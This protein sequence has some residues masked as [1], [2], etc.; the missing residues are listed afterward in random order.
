MSFST[1]LTDIPFYDHLANALTLLVKHLCSWWREA[2]LPCYGSPWCRWVA[3]R[4][5][6]SGTW[7]PAC[8][9]SGS[10]PTGRRKWP[11]SQ[12]SCCR[13]GS[14]QWSAARRRPGSTGRSRTPPTGGRCDAGARRGRKPPP[15]PGPSEPSGGHEAG[16]MKRVPQVK[17]HWHWLST[18]FIVTCTI[19]DILLYYLGGR[20]WIT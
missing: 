7:T 20:R 13:R 10:S 16:G 4:C 17:Y 18:L 6:R 11:G 1:S 5:C 12:R 14:V 19:T 8:K 2:S 9:P 3:S 15:P